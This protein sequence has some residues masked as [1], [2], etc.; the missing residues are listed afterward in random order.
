MLAR[1]GQELLDVEFMCVCVYV[2]RL[3]RFK[4]ED[5]KATRVI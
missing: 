3:L 2:N 1:Q 5:D 4:L